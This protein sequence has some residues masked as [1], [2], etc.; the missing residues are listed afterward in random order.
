VLP[1]TPNLREE[2]GE[3]A[4]QNEQWA[5]LVN[6]GQSLPNPAAHGVLVYAK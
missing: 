6:E 2:V 5:A 3:I 1:L 4:T